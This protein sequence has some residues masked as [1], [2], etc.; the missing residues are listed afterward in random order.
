MQICLEG[1]SWADLG[2]VIPAGQGDN[3]QVDN[4]SI[5]AAR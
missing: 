1:F 2:F 5:L 3:Q 4:K